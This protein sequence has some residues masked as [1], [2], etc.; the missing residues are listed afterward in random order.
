MKININNKQQFINKFLV[1]LNKLNEN[2]IL[3]ITGNKITCTAS[4]NDGVLILHCAYTIDSE[5]EENC[6]LNIPNISKLIKV[7]SCIT[8]DDIQIV[9]DRNC[10]QYTSSDIKFKYHL[11]ED[12]ILVAPAISLDKIKKLDFNTHAKIDYDSISNLLRGSTFTTDTNKI[13]FSTKDG[14]L[15]GELTDKQKHNVDSYTQF[16]ASEYKG[17]DLA[18]PLPLDFE[19][20]RLISTIRF[21]TIN[22]HIA[23]AN[24]V[25]MFDI[26]SENSKLNYIASGFTK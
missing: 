3:K 23:Q 7:L 15:Y 16:I 4:T 26:D 17:D 1:P 5:V 14:A 12:G 21:D 25:F 19:V 6:N 22:M 11:L 8:S 10:L 20:V 13:Y 24:N 18:V 9:Y 2:L